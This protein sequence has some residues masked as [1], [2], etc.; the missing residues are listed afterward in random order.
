MRLPALLL[1]STALI[2]SAD[3]PVQAVI[4]R[5]ARH[6]E[7]VQT[8]YRMWVQTG[9]DPN[10]F[11]PDCTAA[12]KQVDADLQAGPKGELLEALLVSK[13]FLSALAG[14]PAAERET[15]ARRVQREVPGRS[16]AWAI[17]PGMLAS[18]A[19]PAMEAEALASNPEPRVRA[20]LLAAKGERA[21]R[22]S[23]AEE[24][25]NLLKRLQGEFP[26]DPATARFKQAYDLAKPTFRGSTV[27][28][29]RIADLEKSGVVYTPDAFKG[30]Y[31][32][33]DFWASWC[34]PCKREMP[35]LHRSWERFRSKPFEILSLSFDEARGDV[36]AYRKGASTPMPWRHAFVE[37]G[38]ESSLAKAFGVTSIP[39]PVLVGP[40]GKI[41][42]S[43]DELRD[44]NLIETLEK[45]LGK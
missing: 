33:L 3:D 19:T 14:L 24:A 40:D 27:P 10:R 9:R 44:E 15:L 30:K 21:L 36:A 5:S 4:K 13:L 8:S 28:A 18:L 43:G 29:F 45:C 23:R 38:F 20:V 32:L 34:G 31:L 17:D 16:R 37:G 39:R 35:F 25:G 1:A 42:A 6:L 41:L 7:S 26:K 2:A 22:E 11:R 12:L